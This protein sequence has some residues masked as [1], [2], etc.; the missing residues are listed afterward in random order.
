MSANRSAAVMQQRHE[1]HDSL[2]D[3]PT[4]PWAT[5]ALCEMLAAMGHELSSCVAADPACN[6]GFMAEPLREYFAQVHATDIHDYGYGAM[7]ARC[8]FLL[9]WAYDKDDV[10]WI[11]TNPPFKIADDFIRIALS[12]ARVGVAVFVRNAFDEGAGRYDRLFRDLPEAYAFPF[13]E[14]VPLHRGKLRDPGRRYWDPTAK[15]GAGDWRRPSTATA[16]QWLVWLVDQP[17]F[18][19]IKK[20]IAPCR[21]RLIR[22]RDYPIRY[23]DEEGRFVPGGANLF[24]AESP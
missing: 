12:Y 18:T 15:D 13:V 5:R 8:D 4:H 1:P 3:F 10:D 20:R 7:N 2:D 23:P 24:S 16:Y 22:P 19:T 9:D 6:R 11:I 14:R 17:Q 21:D